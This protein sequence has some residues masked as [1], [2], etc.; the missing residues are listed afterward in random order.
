[1]LKTL[2]KKQMM[3]IF[4]GYFYNSRKNEARSKS[5]TVVYFVIF[6]CVII[7]AV[8]GIFTILSF[9]L[10]TDMAKVGMSW[11]YFAI[12]G[13][14]AIIMGTFGSVF[15]T[16]PTLY[17]AKDN[18]L[19]L[20]M[21]IP[22]SKIMITRLLSV[23][24]MS[25]IYSGMV[26]IPAV[27]V[28]L[29][30]VPLSINAL[31]GCVLLVLLI[32][33]FVLTLSC[34][35]GWVVA[36]IS[37]KLKNKSFITMVVSLLFFG[38]YYFGFYKS[39]ELID[40]LLAN[41]VSYGTAIKGNA[42]P[43]YVF[44]SV[45]IGDVLSMLIVT[46][47]VAVVFA[48]MWWLMSRSFIKITTSQT[49]GAK[50]KYKRTFIKQKSID[51]ALFAREV[52]RFTSSPNYMLNCGFGMIMLPLFAVFML[53]KG[54]DTVKML[55][56]NA[57]DNNGF[58]VIILC[59]A[60]CAMASMIDISAPSVSL[61]GKSIWIAQ[62]LPVTAWQVLRVKLLLH[63]VLSIVPTLICQIVLVFVYPFSTFEA[64]LFF[65]IPILIIFLSA[66]FGLFLGIKMVNLNWVS[67][68]TPI[69]QSSSVLI[70]LF[71]GI[72]YSVMLL[73]GYTIVT[74]LLNLSIS[75]IAYMIG[76]AVV[77]FVLNVLLYM[78][79]KKK[80]TAIFATL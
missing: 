70:T 48:L 58:V 2:L 4:R 37:L 46:A 47:V 78:W 66:Q 71:G 15:N 77:T 67:E 32:S 23:Y 75:I 73:W 54:G 5:S 69:K 19:L 8:G 22:V 39:Q 57:G 16:F 9:V 44:G 24:I 76:F 18:D 52:K 13:M 26:I 80:G 45:G 10:C 33:V 25:F 6:A 35:L 72:G 40:A 64:I 30:T 41:L 27:M 49:S 65:I 60:V 21:P 51:K 11:L 56:E 79:L 17:L 50:K 36:K 29:L 28:Y 14:I 34:A 38:L 63:F 3:E 1:M 55:S 31:I 68:I 20:S 43:V 61:E 59:V 12:M 53:I 7:G 74:F 62:S 42:Y